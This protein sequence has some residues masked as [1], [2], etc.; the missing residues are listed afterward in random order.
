MKIGAILTLEYK[1]PGNEVEKYHCKIIDR[2]E[3]ELIIDYPI[4]ALTKK[5]KFFT[6]GSSF[7]ASYVGDEDAVYQFS[8][9]I[10]GRVKLNV[11]GIIISMPDQGEIDRV[12]RREFVR[13][14]AAVDVSVH[15]LD[16]TFTPFTSITS[17]ISGGG[18]SII[19]TEPSR[20]KLGQKLDIWLALP[21]KTERIEYINNI[22]QVVFIQSKNKVDTISVKFSSLNQQEQQKIISFCFEKQRE[23]RKKELT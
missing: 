6:T 11:P 15:S 21:L 22:A 4:H 16:Q 1:L 23:A 13:V 14:N 5:T 7:A 10:M 19:T 2:T 3:N 8:T 20:F 9:E 18:L 12:Q 17:D